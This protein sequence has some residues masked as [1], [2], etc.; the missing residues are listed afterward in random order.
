MAVAVGEPTVF[1]SSMGVENLQFGA[2]FHGL[3]FSFNNKK[4]GFQK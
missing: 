1:S 3:E 4:G 2:G